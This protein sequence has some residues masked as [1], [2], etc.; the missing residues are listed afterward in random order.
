[1]KRDGDIG[2]LCCGG[3]LEMIGLRW[4]EKSGS[5]ARGSDGERLC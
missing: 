3:L 2:G 1:M 5:L 4:D